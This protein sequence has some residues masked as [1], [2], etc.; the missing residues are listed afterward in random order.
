MYKLNTNKV[1]GVLFSTVNIVDS[2]FDHFYNFYNF[3]LKIYI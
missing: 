1:E 3:F 2:P